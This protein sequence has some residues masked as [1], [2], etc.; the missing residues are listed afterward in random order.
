MDLEQK[1]ERFKN[2]YNQIRVH[3]SLEGATPEEKAG[4]EMTQPVDL[5][6]YR[7]QAHCHGLFD[8]PIAA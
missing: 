4:G 5:G 1:L 3:Q 2:Y 8:L 7:W 6:N